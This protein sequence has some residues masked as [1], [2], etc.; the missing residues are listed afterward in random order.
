MQICAPT[1][2]TRCL[3]TFASK[4]TRCNPLSIHCLILIL[5]ALFPVSLPG[6]SMATNLTPFESVPAQFRFRSDGYYVLLPVAHRVG[7]GEFRE[8]MSACP[9]RDHAQMRNSPGPELLRITTSYLWVN[10]CHHTLE[11]CSIQRSFAVPNRQ[12]WRAGSN[13]RVTIGRSSHEGRISSLSVREQFLFV[14]PT[15]LDERPQKTS[16][17]NQKSTSCATAPKLKTYP[18]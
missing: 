3:P 10:M 7:T 17:I 12:Y 18:R 9:I 15:Y 4:L 13:C 16:C 14:I 8:I 6:T 5:A 2:S 11:C 1:N